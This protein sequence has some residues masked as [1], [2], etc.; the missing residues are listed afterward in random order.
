MRASIILL[1]LAAPATAGPGVLVKQSPDIG[2]MPALVVARLT[3]PSI[4]R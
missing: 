4:C 2:S 1:A 3:R